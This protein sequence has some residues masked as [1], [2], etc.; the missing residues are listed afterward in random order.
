MLFKKSTREIGADGEKIAARF[1][2]KNGYKIK[3]MNFL[4]SHGEIDIIAENKYFLVFVEVKSRKDSAEN[5]LNFGLP[6]EAVDKAKQKHIIYTA[7]CYLQRFPTKK[8][9][10]FDV[11]EVYLGD[12]IKIN[13]ISDIADC[14]VVPP[15]VE[16]RAAACYVKYDRKTDFERAVHN[17]LGNDF[18]LLSRNDVINKG[19]LGGGKSHPKTIDFIGDYMICAIADKGIRYQTLNMKPKQMNKANHGGLTDAEMITIS[20]S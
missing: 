3:K 12:E 1:L 7:R 20:A 14:L 10:R 11:I 19:I 2:K 13:H 9:M 17:Y 5:F 18:L 4:S 16:S 15:F 8:E 6:C